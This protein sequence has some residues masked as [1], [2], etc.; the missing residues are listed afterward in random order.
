MTPELS[1]VISPMLSEWDWLTPQQSDNIISFSESLM[2]ER[3]DV[4]IGQLC[5]RS[6]RF[7]KENLQSN[8][9]SSLT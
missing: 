9:S 4:A 2:C 1:T 3:M 8:S 7:L 6:L 5:A